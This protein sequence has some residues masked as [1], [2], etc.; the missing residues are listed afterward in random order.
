MDGG[1]ALLIV[2]LAGLAVVAMVSVAGLAA[3][4]GWLALRSAQLAQGGGATGGHI[5]VAALRSRVKRLEAIA[6][7]LDG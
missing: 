5:D 7:G 2:A 4:R 6:S 3:W 1:P